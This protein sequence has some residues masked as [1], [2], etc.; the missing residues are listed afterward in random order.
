[1]DLVRSSS[2]S[3]V[4]CPEP[5]SLIGLQVKGDTVTQVEIGLEYLAVH[6]SV[7]CFHVVS[8]SVPIMMT[9]QDIINKSQPDHLLGTFPGL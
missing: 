6:V 1:M 2:R 4:L 5:M 3:Y 7:E 8:A 9:M